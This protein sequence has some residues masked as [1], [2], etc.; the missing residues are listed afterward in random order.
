MHKKISIL[1]FL[2]YISLA[3]AQVPQ[4][5]KRFL[6]TPDM[7]GCSFSI[8]VQD[9]HNKEILYSYDSQ[10]ELIPAS[11][12]K[13]V[14]T[15]TALEILG[16]DYRYPTTI[17][18]D[19]VITNGTL[20]GNLYIKGSGDPTLESSH[21]PME[22]RTAIPEWIAAIQQVGIRKITGSV[23]ADESILDTEGV[24]LKWVGEDYG[25][26]YGAGSYGLSFAD[27]Q[28]TLF[29]KTTTPGSR[30]EII[31][32][33][34]EVTGLKFHNYLTS[35]VNLSDSA[36]IVGG[37]FS[38]ERYLYGIIP[39][40]KK[41]FTLKGDIPDPAL[42]LAEYVDKKLKDNGIV[43]ESQ[44][45]CYRLLS[46]SK[47]WP[48]DERKEIITTY[49]PPI[50][51]IISITN[52]VSHNLYADA[53]IKTIGLQYTPQKGEI[54]SSFGRGIKVLKKYWENKGIDTRSLWMFD[55]SGLAI[56]DKLTASFMCELLSYMVT[57]SPNSEIFIASLPEAGISGSIKNFL[58][59]TTLEGNA[60]LKSGSMSRVKGYAGYIKKNGKHYA[61][62]LF[63]N[64][65]SCDGRPM[66][67]AIEQLLV[68]LFK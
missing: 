57:Q 67:Q 6:N 39:A 21:I 34:P 24:G 47:S 14:T 17:E 31:K 58:K 1:L 48:F 35:S 41:Q 13:T 55:G 62:A 60:R 45:S 27:N 7:Q 42:F 53:L 3:S 28:Y 51:E 61:V 8:L 32:T 2:C 5:I 18:Y 44:A 64:N 19:G 40:G 4:P 33:T 30:P 68:S 23:I 9:I 12:M 20:N 38:R 11:V 26:Y 46:E 43:I 54:L 49:S 56:T 37:P 65:Y 25:S 36:Y 15:A 66:N 59:G 52:H 29:L 63:V 10:R 50:S 16:P 22:Q